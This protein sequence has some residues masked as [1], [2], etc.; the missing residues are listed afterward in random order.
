MKEKYLF[1]TFVGRNEHQ[2]TLACPTENLASITVSREEDFVTYTK[3]HNRGKTL[4]GPF[5]ALP[6]EL[7]QDPNDP[8]IVK[9]VVITSDEVDYKIEKREFQNK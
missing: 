5:F 8:N 6:T 4:I 1:I 9:R 2:V 7:V 3:L